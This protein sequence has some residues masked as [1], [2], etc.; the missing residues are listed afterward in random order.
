MRGALSA[1]LLVSACACSAMAQGSGGPVGGERATD[2]DRAGGGGAGEWRLTLETEPTF[3]FRAD[4]D[5]DA[6]EVSIFRTDFSADFSGPVGDKLR[7]SIGLN[8]GWANYD[9]EDFNAGGFTDAP[10]DD[11]YEAGL[12]L[13]GIY[14]LDEQWFLVGRGS[15]ASGWADDADV[16]DGVF[17]S[18]AAGLG[19]TFSDSFRLALGG[20][21]ITR[22]EDDIGFLPLFILDWRISETV[23]LQTSGVGMKL[24]AELNDQWSVYLRGGGQF[25]QYR[26]D[27]DAERADGGRGGAIN[28][29]RVP[30]GVGFD[31]RPAEG[32]TV[33]FEGG[34]I[35]W[36]EF[37]LRD[38]DRKLEEI[39]TDPAGYIGARLSYRF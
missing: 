27:D 3:T 39:E 34:A 9:F 28:D 6:G 33:S 24:S 36:Q 16:G 13:L 7:L 38:D 22:L 32:L 14:T 15:V 26:L 8:G 20:G 10:L 18:A 17:G 29:T 21:I 11:A 23:R 30:V 35:V 5:D 1:A 12:S 2:G 25:H 4:M 31:W 37:E 19:Y